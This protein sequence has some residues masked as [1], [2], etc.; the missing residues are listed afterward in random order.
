M[1]RGW[2]SNRVAPAPPDS[3]PE[4]G[5][6]GSH[7][8]H[9]SQS[10]T[11]VTDDDSVADHP[12]PGAQPLGVPTRTLATPSPLGTANGF[13][14]ISVLTLLT[15]SPQLY[16]TP[17]AARDRR[18]LVP[19]LLGADWCL[20]SYVMTNSC[21][22]SSGTVYP[23]TPPA[24]ATAAE[25]PGHIGL[26]RVHS[27]P[28]EGSVVGP[29]DRAL[30]RRVLQLDTAAGARSVDGRN[31]IARGAGSGSIGAL[32]GMQTGRLRPLR[33]PQA[34]HAAM[35]G[36]AGGGAE[37]GDKA[38]GGPVPTR[39]AWGGQSASIVSVRD[40]GSNAAVVP[41]IVRA[42][43]TLVPRSYHARATLPPQHTHI[44]NGKVERGD[45][46]TGRRGNGRSLSTL[47]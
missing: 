19:M 34:S 39:E 41:P 3:P 47:F 25:I 18:H 45:G 26:G 8:S 30:P 32:G 33:L 22:F 11:D 6:R 7:T 27:L 9:L 20:Q 38:A 42:C 2:G 44:T 28:G 21:L 10:S 23:E 15:F 24:A 43:T 37:T 36:P 29:G 31:A 13:D 1:P 14:I 17:H 35:A 4:G 40:D 5:R 46:E 12:I 16:I